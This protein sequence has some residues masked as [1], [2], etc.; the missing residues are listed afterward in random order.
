MKLNQSSVI[1]SDLQEDGYQ[2]PQFDIT[3]V[4]EKTLSEPTWLQ[5]G[6]GNIF[7]AFL[8]SCQ[9][10][11]L[12]DDVA[13][14]GIIV[15]EGYDYEIVD[16]LRAYDFLTINV[17]LKA[18]GAVEKEVIGSI[19][20]YLKMDTCS[21]DFSRM[22]SIFESESLQMVSLTIT[23]KGYR[24]IDNKGAIQSA[25]LHDF[26]HGPLQPVSYLGK[27]ASLLVKRFEAGAFPLALVS[28]DNM[29]HNGEKLRHS[30][31]RFVDEWQNRGLVSQAFACYVK[32]DRKITFPWSMIDKI[33]P[34]PD[35]TVQQMLE[36]SGLTDMAPVTTDKHTFVAPYVNGEETQYLIIE[37]AFPNGRPALDKAGVIFTTR[38]TVNAVETMKVSTCLNPLHTA[39]AIFGCLLGYDSIHKEMTD[40]SLV[41]LIKRLGYQEG[42]PVVTDPKILNPKAFIDEVINVRLP[43]PFIPDTP[44]RIA[45]DTSQKL[46]ARFGETL[47]AYVTKDRDIS[48]LEAIPLV[49]AG[50]LRYLTGINDKG[51]SFEI[52]T[53]PLGDTLL[54][55]FAEFQF[56]EQTISDEIINLLKD[57][58]IFSVNLYDI[59]IAEKVI[60]Y[61]QQMCIQA[62]SIQNVL[63]K[64]MENER[65][66]D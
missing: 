5:L 25:V 12:N 16:V 3:A 40:D 4:K 57:T 60:A 31:L 37:D 59:G 61:Y 33:T 41:A 43:N 18:N 35:L 20:D 50:W 65:R 22:Q 46:S 6:A 53:D 14:T 62:G 28:M 7:R 44:Q 63:E 64:F 2:L 42:L 58:S 45:T 26:V 15:A 38:E 51:E 39:L 23:E 36:K 27:L 54:P 34:R 32:D 21:E 49:F 19:V 55:K 13:D 66:N 24:L 10:K 29:S 1:S 17:K 52:S 9:Q 11:L 8:G 56:G 30:I 47:K 48:S